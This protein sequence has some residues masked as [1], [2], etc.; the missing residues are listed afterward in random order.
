MFKIRYPWKYKWKH[1]NLIFIFLSTAFAVYMLRTPEIVYFI[2]HSGN[3]G[4]LG[5]L[6]AG[7][8][9]SSMFT[10]PIAM[11]A[12]VILGN[13]LEPVWIAVVGALGAM[14]ADF[15]IFQFVRRSIDSLTEDIAELKIFIERH[16][17]IHTDPNSVLIHR[18]KVYLAPVLAGL[19]IASPLPDEIA[20]GMLGAAHYDKKKVLVFAFVANFLGI[21]ALAYVGRYVL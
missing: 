1:K 4:Y 14:T 10:T 9:F 11:A 6:I 19:I 8:F 13:T 3:L 17:P 12:L 18:L 16:N 5:A 21:L 20:I 15:M 7:F 2:E